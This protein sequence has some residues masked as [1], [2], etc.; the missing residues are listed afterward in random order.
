MYDEDQKEY[1]IKWEDKSYFHC[2]WMPGAWVWGVTAPTMRKAFVRRDEGANLLPKW[3]SEEAIPEEFL[4]MEI[5]FDVRYSDDF[6]PES[7]ATDKENIADVEEVLVKFQGLGYEDSVWQSRPT[8]EETTLWAAFVSAYNEYVVGKYFEQPSASEMKQNIKHFRALDFEN[9]IKVQKQPTALTGGELMPYQR[10]GLNWLLEKYHSQRNVILADEMGLG[11][12]I[13]IIS[14]L[15]S[16]IK[17]SPQCSPFLVVTPNSTCPNW[18]R[19]LKQ[20]APSLR[21]VA[22]YGGKKARDMAMK[23]ELYPDGAKHLCADV[24]ITS[25]EAPGDPDSR[26]FFKKIKWAGMIVD[27]GQRLK[28]DANQLYLALKAMNVPFRVLLTGTPLQNNTRELFN[29][30][31]FLDEK[32]NAAELDEKYKVLTNDNIKEL[33]S[34]IEPFFL[35][36]TKLQVLKFLPP[37]AQVIIPV[38][39]SVLQKKLYKSILAKNPELIKSI[40]GQSTALVR[41]QERGSLNNILMQLRKVLCHPFIY[42]SAVEEKSTSAEIDYR[43]LVDASSKLQLL[44]IMLPKLRERGHRVLIFSQ[45][46]EQ[47]TVVEDFLDYLDLPFKRLD[48]NIDARE[49]MKRIDAFNA[50]NSPLFAFLLSTRAGG[51]G[52]NLATA[53]TVIIMD[54]DF[55]PHQDMQALSRAHRIGQK[56]KVLVFQLLTKDTAEE[57][58]AQIGRKKMALDHALIETMGADDD[59]PRDLE[60]ILRYGAEALFN[61]DDS[62]D[63]RYDAASIDKLLDRTH[64]ENTSTDDNKNGDAAFSHARVWSNDKSGLVEDEG[65]SEAA[66]PNASVWEKILKQREADAAAEAAKNMVKFGRGQRVRQTVDYHK[67][68][69]QLDDAIES[70]PKKSRKQDSESDIEFAAGADSDD[71]DMDAPQPGDVDINEISTGHARRTSGSPLNKQG[72]KAKKIIITTP[73]KKVAAK[74]AAASS[75]TRNIR[76][77]VKATVPAKKASPPKAKQPT[78]NAAR[79]SNPSVPRAPNGEAASSMPKY[80]QHKA[81]ATKVTPQGNAAKQKNKVARP[82]VP[83]KTSAQDKVSNSAAEPGSADSLIIPAKRAL[84][85]TESSVQDQEVTIQ[86]QKTAANTLPS[87]L[88]IPGTQTTDTQSKTR[89]VEYSK[90]LLKELPKDEALPEKNGHR[91]DHTQ[92]NQSSPTMA[93]LE[94][95]EVL[96]TLSDPQAQALAD[97]KSQTEETTPDQ[98]MQFTQDKNTNGTQI[99]SQ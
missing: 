44:E 58:I 96:A 91:A 7:E 3:T 95:Q 71:D 54:A 17:D 69:T 41:P 14:V 67:S 26:S 2:T 82:V 11:K 83:K 48:G 39:M 56:K 59:I 88:P 80:S 42:S 76:A 98:S 31:Q 43:N 52:I 6:E 65:E 5:I 19:E 12:T 73:T 77:K 57:R 18:R 20:W 30:I 32:R 78:K 27:E 13:Q 33:Q 1:L 34:E 23:Y 37:M 4:R 66:L 16:L 24:V 46:L 99:Q 21:V 64:V 47:L 94:T 15:A 68:D 79:I 97:H 40:F 74:S 81:P 38:T 85:S 22:Y 70:S 86:R 63:I 8:P 62:N 92:E 35:R 60:S 25:Y 49:K 29:L 72:T 36:R 10:S 84:T 90:D 55:N 28:N 45:F 87:Q 93:I 61:D 51:V 75:G 53:D 50:P 9:D 89:E